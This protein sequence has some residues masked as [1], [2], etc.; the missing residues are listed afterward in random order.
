VEPSARVELAPF[1]YR[2]SALPLSYDGKLMVD[3][4]G[5]EPSVSRVRAGCAS[6]APRAQMGRSA[7]LEP[8]PRESQTR[9]LPLRNDHRVAASVRP[10]GIEPSS[11][12]Y[13]AAALPLCYGRRKLS[14]GG[15]NRT[16][17]LT[18]PNRARFRCATPRGRSGGEQGSRTLRSVWT[19]RLAD[20]HLAPVQDGLSVRRKGRESFR[21]GTVRLRTP[22][23]TE[24]HSGG[25]AAGR[26]AAPYAWRKERESNPQGSS[27]IR[28]RD[29]CHHPLACPSM[30]CCRGS[31]GNRTHVLRFKRPVQRQ[32]LLPTRGPTPRNRTETFRFSG[33]RADQLRQQ[34]D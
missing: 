30:N 5:F 13:R 32:R 7:G 14:R 23:A 24:T 12:A 3:S 19:T 17:D 33:G 22:A 29:G 2:G 25:E 4:E 9:A 31:G 15:G 6:V 16:H 20:G 27:L 10:E 18:V 26:E 8:A 34:W 21:A 11:A 1:P 28:F